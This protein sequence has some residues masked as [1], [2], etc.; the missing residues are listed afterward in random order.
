[1]VLQIYV[2]Q[3]KLQIY[4]RLFLFCRSDFKIKIYRNLQAFCIIGV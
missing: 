2:L 4:F 1:M 3:Y